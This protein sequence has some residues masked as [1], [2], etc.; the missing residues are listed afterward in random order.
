MSETAGA[1]L[2]RDGE[3]ERLRER[4]RE[5]G[6]LQTG[7]S[8]TSLIGQRKVEGMNASDSKF[9]PASKPSII[10]AEKRTVITWQGRTTHFASSF[11][12]VACNCL[13]LFLVPAVVFEPYQKGPWS[14][15]K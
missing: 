2:Q 13:L 11:R 14:H 8:G 9:L 7:S 5:G 1:W 15:S 6:P 3:G 12:E 10:S 4:G